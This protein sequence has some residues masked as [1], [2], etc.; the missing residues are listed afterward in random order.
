MFEATVGP[1]ATF[2]CRWTCDQGDKKIPI[3][4][5]VGQVGNFS[6]CLEDRLSLLNIIRKCAY[7]S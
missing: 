2:T 4:S 6:G 5:T 1:C 7:L 3:I